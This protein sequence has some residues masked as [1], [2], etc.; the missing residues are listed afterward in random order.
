MSITFKLSED[1]TTIYL[2]D[3]FDY[4]QMEEFK[5]IYEN[6]SDQ[7]F[8]IDFRNTN[9]M[10]SSGL[11]ML[12]NMKRFSEGKNIELLNCKDQIKKV[13]VMSRFDQHFA[14]H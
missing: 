13:L 5:N 11:G 9:Y 8:I 7:D 10:D 3:K 4:S 14:I 12:L 2:G 6:N 1:K